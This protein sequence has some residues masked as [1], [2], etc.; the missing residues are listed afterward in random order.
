MGIPGFVFNP[1]VDTPEHA[2]MLRDARRSSN[3]LQ[4]TLTSVPTGAYNVYV[5]TF[6]PNGPSSLILSLEQNVASNFTTGAAGS[7]LRLGP[8]PI[9]VDD[10]N[11][12]IRLQTTVRT[13]A[14]C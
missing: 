3:D 10:G 1:A 12:Q 2:S 9:N 7:W 8:F 4:F 5:W 13:A 14:L 6:E 11:A